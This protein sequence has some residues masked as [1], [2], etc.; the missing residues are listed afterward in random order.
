MARECSEPPRGEVIFGPRLGVVV[1]EVE[2]HMLEH[3]VRE[4]QL[5][6]ARRMSG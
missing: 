3:S 6:A 5:A 1:D 2:L 4:R